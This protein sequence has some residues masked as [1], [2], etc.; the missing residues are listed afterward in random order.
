MMFHPLTI[1][2]R[3]EHEL[4]VSGAIE[5]PAIDDLFSQSNEGEKH[6]PRNGD[7]RDYHDVESGISQG[8][9]TNYA[10]HSAPAYTVAD[11]A[12]GFEKN[13]DSHPSYIQHSQTQSHANPF[14]SPADEND[15]EHFPLDI[16]DGRQLD[17]GDDHRVQIS[18]HHYRDGEVGSGV[19]I[20]ERDVGRFMRCFIFPHRVDTQGLQSE[21]VNALLRI[22]VPK[23]TA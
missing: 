1:S 15:S 20:G 19:I 22:G 3:S 14:V 23:A 8:C 4:L 7:K 9:T 6:P 18:T 21:I 5:R 11:E 12:N 13:D 2:W 17:E 10:Q 16:V